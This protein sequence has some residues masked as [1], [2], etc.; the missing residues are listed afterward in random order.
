MTSDLVRRSAIRIGRSLEHVAPP[1]MAMHATARID[2]RWGEAELRF[3]PALLEPTHLALDVGAAVD[4][5]GEP[6]PSAVCLIR[7]L[8]IA[9][10]RFRNP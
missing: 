2:R 3:L 4:E 1:H 7:P 6:L 8:A 10:F 5:T 9:L